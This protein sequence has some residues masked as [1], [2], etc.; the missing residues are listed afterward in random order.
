MQS[1]KKKYTVA[2]GRHRQLTITN[3]IACFRNR[4][5][6]VIHSSHDYLVPDICRIRDFFP[7]QLPASLSTLT[8]GII[9]KTAAV[10]DGVSEK[11]YG[12]VGFHLTRRKRVVMRAIIHFFAKY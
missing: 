4:F 2:T 1:I 6:R 10:L 8:N 12:I 3:A 9:K 7:P 11:W 5:R